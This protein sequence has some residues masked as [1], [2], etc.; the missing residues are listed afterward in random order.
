MRRL[1]WVQYRS[2]SKKRLV[3]TLQLSLIKDHSNASAHKAAIA[4]K[5]TRDKCWIIRF[6]SKKEDKEQEDF[7]GELLRKVIR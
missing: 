2:F 6:L 3:E 1:H 7:K 5:Q 4:S